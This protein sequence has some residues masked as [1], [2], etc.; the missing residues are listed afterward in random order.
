MTEK[1]ANMNDICRVIY[2]VH[3][4]I[5]TITKKGRG[6]YKYEFARL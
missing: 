5:I 6:V 1:D 3:H 4:V 2:C